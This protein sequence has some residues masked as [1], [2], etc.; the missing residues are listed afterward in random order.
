MGQQADALAQPLD[1]LVGTPQKLAQHAEKVRRSKL[2]VFRT[3]CDASAFLDP[4]IWCFSPRASAGQ[5]KGHVVC[6]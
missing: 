2:R 6:C 3:C 5:G 1:I 4:Q